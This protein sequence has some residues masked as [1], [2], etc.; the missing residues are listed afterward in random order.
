MNCDIGIY[1]IAWKKSFTLLRPLKA[2]FY[3]GSVWIT[4]S[5]LTYHG[6]NEPIV[7]DLGYI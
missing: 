1:V 6:C 2:H 7:K 3:Y 4:L 5:E